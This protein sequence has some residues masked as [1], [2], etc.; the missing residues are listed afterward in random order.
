MLKFITRL[1]FCR[2]K[3]SDSEKYYVARSIRVFANSKTHSLGVGSVILDR[4]T[5]VKEELP[6]GTWRRKTHI[7][8][9]SDTVL[10]PC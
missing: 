9:F 4:K 3:I 6:Q 1:F 2:Y 5:G 7:V 10:D 8:W